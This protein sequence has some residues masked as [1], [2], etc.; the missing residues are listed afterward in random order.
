MHLLRS[1]LSVIFP[2]ENLESVL[3]LNDSKIEIYGSAYGERILYNGKDIAY[4]SSINNIER[5]DNAIIIEGMVYDRN[6][7]FGFSE[8]Q[9]NPNRVRIEIDDKGRIEYLTEKY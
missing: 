5:R 1:L 4:L 6:D 9:T 2:K 8:Y 3:S 7:F